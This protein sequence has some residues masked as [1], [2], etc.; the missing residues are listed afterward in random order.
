MS[1]LEFISEQT[2]EGGNFYDKLINPNSSDS[3]NSVLKKSNDV[4]KILK[5]AKNVFT[6]KWDNG[7]SLNDIATQ[8]Y[9]KSFLWQVVADANNLDPFSSIELEK[10]LKVP[11][12]N[13]LVESAKKYVSTPDGKVLID[14]VEN[15]ILDLTGIGSKTPFAKNL[16]ECINK[17]IE[18][19]T[20]T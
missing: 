12:Y 1:V 5:D 3:V 4:Q 15:S 20:T 17:I 8:T 19:K 9:G 6:V 18:F 2:I 10:I 13:S 16:K 7:K 11:T 14:K